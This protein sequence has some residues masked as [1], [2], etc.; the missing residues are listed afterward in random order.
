MADEYE[1]A[2][3]YSDRADTALENGKPRDALAHI[4][5]AINIVPSMQFFWSIKADC[6]EQLGEKREASSCY[7]RII[8][9]CDRALGIDPMNPAIWVDK[10]MALMSLERLD[11]GL[12][13]SERA[14]EVY[15]N[16]RG[17]WFLKGA[18]LQ[19]MGRESEGKEFWNQGQALMQEKTNILKNAAAN[20]I[21]GIG[22]VPGWVIEDVLGDSMKTYLQLID[23]D[24]SVAEE[25]MGGFP[26]VSSDLGQISSMESLPE[27]KPPSP[28]E[29]DLDHSTDETKECPYCAEIIKA[30][31]IKCRFCGSVLTKD[32]QPEYQNNPVGIIKRDICISGRK[33]FSEGER[34]TIER[35]APNNEKPEFKYVV[36]SDHL[37]TK[38]LLSDN[39]VLFGV[40]ESPAPSISTFYESSIQ[41]LVNAEEKLSI[42][43]LETIGE[44][45]EQLPHEDQTDQEVNTLLRILTDTYASRFAEFENEGHRIHSLAKGIIPPTEHQASHAMFLETLELLLNSI[46]E[47]ISALDL[48]RDTSPEKAVIFETVWTNAM[49]KLQESNQHTRKWTEVFREVTKSR[50]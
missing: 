30:K 43:M 33:A 45:I 32:L 18:I 46:S 11:Q 16:Y 25:S 7:E 29:R 28:S 34:V 35:V 10:G 48:L 19:E 8:R 15:P 50:I 49:N 4:N 9:I 36:L 41:D 37:Q 42:A 31:A 12:F 3:E 27:G 40:K 6:H 23:C 17:G 24:F 1:L 38:Y 14:I 22:I 39:D 44:V 20:A 2:W 21:D 13:C 5:E 47:Y 26:Q